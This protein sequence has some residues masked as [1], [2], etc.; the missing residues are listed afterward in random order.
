[1]TR[2][3]FLPRLLAA[4]LAAALALTVGFAAAQDAAEES[5]A[6]LA[7]H[8]LECFHGVGPDIFEKCHDN[9]V[10]DIGFTVNGAEGT[11]DDAGHVSFHGPA[12]TITITEDPD[13]FADY[14]GAYVYCAEQNSGTV[15][16]DGSA[17][18]TGGVVTITV[19]NGDDVICD[20]YDITEEPAEDGTTGGGV[21]TLPVTGAGPRDAAGAAG[22]G[23]LAVLGLVASTCAM[24]AAAGRGKRASR[25]A[26]G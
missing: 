25:G 15:L 10:S 19:E 4:A 6:T 21:T 12:A 11:T 13:D 2:T 23:F 8:K 18:D 16:F 24:R 22:A 7:I 20:W 3:T 14:L 9:P 1:M 17:T 5:E 26:R